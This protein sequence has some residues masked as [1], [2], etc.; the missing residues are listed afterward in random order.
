MGSYRYRTATLLGPWRDTAE[1][2]VQDA[3]R[4]KQ[5]RRD[6]QGT[7]WHWVVPGSIEEG[8]GTP[9]PFAGEDYFAFS[10]S[11]PRRR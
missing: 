3:I 8:H 6:E 5:A 11:Q 1:A 7:G 10:G 4:A 2:A 9:L